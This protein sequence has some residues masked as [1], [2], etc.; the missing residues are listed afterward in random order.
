MIDRAS[1][2]Y[3]Y[4]STQ[5]ERQ[6]IPNPQEYKQSNEQIVQRQTGRENFVGLGIT[7][8]MSHH[9]AL[10]GINN[11]IIRPIKN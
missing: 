7:R 2:H 8:L 11:N 4:S 3:A 5:I 6:N 1:T 9:A 10:E